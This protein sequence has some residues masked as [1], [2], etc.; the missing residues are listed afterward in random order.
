MLE[1]VGGSHHVFEYT[2][3]G[4][5]YDADENAID[6]RAP[7]VIPQFS[8]EPFAGRRGRQPGREVC[9]HASTVRCPAPVVTQHRAAHDGHHRKPVRDRF[10]VRERPGPVSAG[11]VLTVARCPESRAQVRARP[12]AGHDLV[13]GHHEHFVATGHGEAHHVTIAV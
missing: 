10:L 3:I 9:F 12:R 5:R 2:G 7:H 11:T 13:A 4:G 8:A 1:D 6:R